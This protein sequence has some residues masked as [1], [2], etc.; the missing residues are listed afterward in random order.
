ML[1]FENSLPVQKKRW[2]SEYNETLQ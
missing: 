2:I 1:S